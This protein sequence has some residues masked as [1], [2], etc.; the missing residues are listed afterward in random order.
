MFGMFSCKAKAPTMPF[1]DSRVLPRRLNKPLSCRL[2]P[3]PRK[4]AGD[5]T[6]FDNPHLL[7]TRILR[8]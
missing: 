3:V 7:N 2:L 5:M 4:I 6:T 8:L 1:A